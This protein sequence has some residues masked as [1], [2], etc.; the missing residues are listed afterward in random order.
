MRKAETKIQQAIQKWVESIGGIAVKV[1]GNAFQRKGDPDL[2]GSIPIF[3]RDYQ[4]LPCSYHIMFQI[5]TKT[6]AGKLSV[7]QK[8]RLK[9]W[10]KH[11][12]LACSAVSVDDL[13][14]KIKAF[15]WADN[16][17][18]IAITFTEKGIRC[19]RHY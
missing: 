7:I 6:E 16:P 8:Y 5:E 14:E 10:R 11:G 15:I 13:Q 3:H 2:R 4:G 17:D 12:Y 1:H 19:E 9:E 18:L